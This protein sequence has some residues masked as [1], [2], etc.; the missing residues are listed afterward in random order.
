MLNLSVLFKIV[1]K[2]IKIIII[3]S[4]RTLIKFR[5][6]HLLIFQIFYGYPIVA[7]FKKNQR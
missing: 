4:S 2:I 7:V 6:E 5:K 3:I 1:F